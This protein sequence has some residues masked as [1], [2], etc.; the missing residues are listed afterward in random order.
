MLFDRY[1]NSV[2]LI[3]ILFGMN[4]CSSSGVE[5]TQDRD[6][7]LNSKIL[8]NKAAYIPSM[9]YTKTVDENGVVHNP[10]YSCHTKS[11]APNFI[12]D[13]DLQLSYSFASY[14]TKNHWSNLFIDRSKDVDKI[15]DDEIEKYVRVSNYFD[16]KNNIILAKKLSNLPKEWD[17]VGNKYWYGYIPDCYFNFDKD[18]FDKNPKTSQYTGWRAFLYTPFLGTFWPTNGSID[19]V[20]IRLSKDF[21]QDVNGEFDIDIYRVNLAIVELL[22]K[23]KD[24]E[25]KPI[26]ESRINFDINHDGVLSIVD[27]IEYKKDNLHYVGKAGILEEEGKIDV[28]EGLFPLGTEFLHTVRYVDVDDSAKVKLAPRMK[29]VRYSKKLYTMTPEDLKKQAEMEAD[30]KM[31]Y[32]NQLEQF[33][34]NFQSGI[35]NRQGWYYQGFIEDAKGDL[36]PQSY[37]ETLYCI[38]CHRGLGATTD[39]IFAFPRKISGRDVPQYG[40]IYAPNLADTFKIK[41]PKRED[42]KYE[43]SFY[44]QNNQAGDEFRGN[45]EVLDKFFNPDSSLK[46]DM[47]DK[48]HSDINILIMPSKSNALKHNKAYRVI[49]KEQ[50]FI[51]G[52]DATIKPAKNVHREVEQNIF[53]G[54][55]EMIKAQ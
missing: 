9:C 49:V 19:D 29:E 23:R 44:L 26:D 20:M 24:V 47:I 4:G 45:E 53:T 22:I 40:W 28:F 41:E 34:G 52:R 43:Y 35:S 48:L 30:D 21:Q 54:V 3:S 17:L 46:E 14:A 37:E 7:D 36:R 51:Y 50:S 25:I 55:S 6:I 42:G 10:C 13:G 33:D 39:G 1:I 31:Y 11:K 27:K 18:G 15:S 38:G 12:N 5:D 32:P 8:Y 16:S 2:L